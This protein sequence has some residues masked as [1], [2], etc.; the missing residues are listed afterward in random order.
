MFCWLQDEGAGI[1][2]IRLLAELSAK[3][4][5][6]ELTDGGTLSFSLAGADAKIDN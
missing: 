6:I 4:D 5:D 1:H 3:R 2:A